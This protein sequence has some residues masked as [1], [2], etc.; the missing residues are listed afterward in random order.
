MP[1]V[2]QGSQ[3]TGLRI[4]APLLPANPTRDALEISLQNPGPD[5]RKTA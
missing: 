1:A 4:P 2:Q 5:A 3:R